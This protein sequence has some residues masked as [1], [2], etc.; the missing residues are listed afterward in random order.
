MIRPVRTASR[1]RA[2]EQPGV[3]DRA[4]GRSRVLYVLPAVIAVFRRVE[5]IAV[6]VF[7]AVCRLS[8]QPRLS[9][10]A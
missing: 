5:N 6:V 2:R 4:A 9:L 8:G 3:L 7:L 10:L 1:D